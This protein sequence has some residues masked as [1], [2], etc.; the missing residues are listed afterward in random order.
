MEHG[1]AKQYYCRFNRLQCYTH[2]FRHVGGYGELVE[3]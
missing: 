3:L 1:D 2:L